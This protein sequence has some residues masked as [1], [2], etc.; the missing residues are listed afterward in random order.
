MVK[1]N[2]FGW[3]LTRLNFV[4]LWDE[5]YKERGLPEESSSRETEI[6]R[7]VSNIISMFCSIYFI[8]IQDGVFYISASG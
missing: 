2:P 6:N 8:D 3:F 5:F 7:T 4:N 1:L